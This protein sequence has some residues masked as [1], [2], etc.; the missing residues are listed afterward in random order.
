MPLRVLL[1]DD[2]LSWGELLCEVMRERGYEVGWFVRA[3]L[4][5]DHDV[6]LMDPDGKTSL[7]QNGDFDLALIDGRLKGSIVNGWEVT[8]RVVAK[9]LPVI[10]MSGAGHFNDQMLA[11]G[12]RE[13]L[14]KDLLFT[15]ILNGKIVLAA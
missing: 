11:A 9:S 10:A 6:K 3:Q 2:D 15:G 12:A 1:L 7:L 8:P 13:T 14:R 4:V 5:G